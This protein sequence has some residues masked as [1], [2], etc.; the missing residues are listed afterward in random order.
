[1]LKPGPR[2]SR[3]RNAVQ[4]EL[5]TVEQR[6]RAGELEEDRTTAGAGVAKWPWEHGGEAAAHRSVGRRA[7]WAAGR[8]P[9]CARSVRQ[10]DGQGSTALGGD[11]REREKLG[12]GAPRERSLGRELQRQPWNG[13]GRWRAGRSRARGAGK[14]TRREQG[15]ARWKINTREWRR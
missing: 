9:G 5:K 2:S 8:Q 13:T 14:K 1:V 15:D 10:G 3:D 7:P 6:A 12:E 11:G 4:G